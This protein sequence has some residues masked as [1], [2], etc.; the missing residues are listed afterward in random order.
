[1]KFPMLHNI[2]FFIYLRKYYT[3]KKYRYAK[4]QV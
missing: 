1:M 2:I 4:A 3:V